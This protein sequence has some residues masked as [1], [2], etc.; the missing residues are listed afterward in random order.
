MLQS[1][2]VLVVE[3]EP[4]IREVLEFFLRRAG[5]VVHGESN[6]QAALDRLLAERYD[7]VVTDFVMPGLSGVQIIKALR[8]RGSSLPVLLLS[9]T[10]TK[11][12]L[13]AARR[14]GAVE[15]LEKPFSMVDLR[16]KVEELLIFQQ[17]VAK[18]GRAS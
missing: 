17:G 18:G 10:V 14:Y 8:A 5:F 11:S 4:R 3:D 2:K 6:G 16:A 9:A 7:L 15:V 1:R 13:H 12:A